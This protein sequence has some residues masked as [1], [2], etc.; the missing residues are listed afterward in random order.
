MPE[1][2]K[3]PDV[4]NYEHVENYYDVNYLN[5]LRSPFYL[6]YPYNPNYTYKDYY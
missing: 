5:Y 4:A 2:V 3:I 1:G 6:Y